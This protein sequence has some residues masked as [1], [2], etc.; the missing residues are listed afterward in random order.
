MVRELM[1][2]AAFSGAAV[3]LGTALFALLPP[4]R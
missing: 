1:T 2:F 4:K 3:L